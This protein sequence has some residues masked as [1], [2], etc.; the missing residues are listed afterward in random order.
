MNKIFIITE[1]FPPLTGATGKLLEELASFLT[2]YYE[3]EVVTSIKD[4]DNSDNNRHYK[5]KRF[6]IKIRDKNKKLNRVI[7]GLKF[8]FLSFFY[9]LFKS[10]KD[11][12]FFVSNPPY[13]AV[14][15]LF[16]KIFKKDK[17]I[18]LIHDIYPEIAINLGYLKWNSFI[19][20]IW[21][22]IN[23]SIFNNSYFVI[24]LGNFMK[25]KLNSLYPKI[26][27]NN[28]IV[29]HNW[30][31]KEKNY[32][33]KDKEELKKRN[34]YENKFIVQYSG[35]IGLF[36][37][38]E[39]LIEVARLLV[40]DDI[41]F[42]IIGNGARKK[43][44]EEKVKEYNLKNV[45]LK[46][47]VPETQLNISLNFCDISCI[48]LDKRVA[49]LC[50]PSKFYSIIATGGVVLGIMEEDTDIGK[51]IID[52]KIGFV[53]SSYNINEIAKKILI[54]YNNRD[55]LKEFSKNSYNLFLR[56]YEKSIIMQEYKKIFKEIIK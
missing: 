27:N 5:I 2:K 12:L 10:K 29:I 37:N 9:L 16:L 24:T 51:E 43:N 15:G 1:I 40:L 53:V 41:L 21:R 22:N 20:K 34:G 3:I 6:N 11:I 31:D 14:I 44:L 23:Y 30:C 19:S 35:N 52:N 38:T 46:D 33:I 45:I 8:L 7:N 56:K 48:T 42:L 36:H 28:F 32:P 39:I 50:V 26:K 54:L 47:L 13:I 18:Y 4:I 25:D 55:I 17:I 49:N